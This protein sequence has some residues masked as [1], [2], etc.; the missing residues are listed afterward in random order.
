MECSDIHWWGSRADKCEGFLLHPAS[1]LLLIGCVSPRLLLWSF[2]ALGLRNIVNISM[3][4]QHFDLCCWFPC[5]D[6]MLDAVLF[7]S[8]TACSQF[9][10]KL[11]LFLLLLLVF[12]FFLIFKLY[13]QLIFLTNH[14][15]ACTLPLKVRKGFR[16]APPHI[17]YLK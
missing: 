10:W 17:L 9:G 3:L 15:T 6:N 4:G 7:A 12:F 2:W 13:I 1:K 5:P 14:S 8:W 11:G 16:R